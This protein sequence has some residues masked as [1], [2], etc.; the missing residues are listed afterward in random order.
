MISNFQ[1]GSSYVVPINKKLRNLQESGLIQI[2]IDDLAANASKC[3]TVP[4]IVSSHGQDDTSLSL[5][6]TESFFSMVIGGYVISA[7]G[8]FAEMIWALPKFIETIS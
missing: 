7:V 8:L 1:K 5:D 6:Q 4:K 2:W 3:E